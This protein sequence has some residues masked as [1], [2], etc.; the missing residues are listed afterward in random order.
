[1]QDVVKQGTSQYNK[2]GRRRH[3]RN[4]SLSYMLIL[5]IAVTA[6]II[7]SVTVFFNIEEVRVVGTSVYTAEEIVKSSGLMAGENMIRANMGKSAAKINHDLVYIEHTKIRRIFPNTVEIE[8]TPCKETAMISF[9]EGYFLISKGRKI[10][11]IT[12]NA[13]SNMITIDGCEPVESLSVG[14]IF[15]SGDENKTKIISQLIEYN[16]ISADGKI[17][18]YN[19][20]DRLNITCLYENRICIEL[21]L[22][23]ELDY[24]IRFANEIIVTKIGKDTEGTLKILSDGEASFLDK[25]SIEENKK[26]YES[27]I[28][29]EIV[30]ETTFSDSSTSSNGKT[31]GM[32]E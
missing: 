4:M 27:N 9:P 29:T 16:S 17:T 30:N 25:L 5:F 28:N 20:S 32:M 2:S 18:E 15:E 3:K 1:M 23:S 8:V 19:I 22:I 26:I 13:R 6:F 21:G 12:E 24:K 7:L 31:T 11:D 14:D 10:L